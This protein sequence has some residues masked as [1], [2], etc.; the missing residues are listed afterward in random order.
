M[1][2]KE[3]FIPINSND[4]IREVRSGRLKIKDACIMYFN[5]GTAWLNGVMVQG[6]EGEDLIELIDWIYTRGTFGDELVLYSMEEILEQGMGDYI[7]DYYIGV[8][9][10]EYF[11]DMIDSIEYIKGGL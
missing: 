9:G 11:T 1:I 4:M 3:L 7:Y 2:I 5:T 10:G 6:R 8:N